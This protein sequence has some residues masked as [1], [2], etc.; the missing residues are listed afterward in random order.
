MTRLAPALSGRR[1]AAATGL[2]LIAGMAVQLAA[3]WPGIMVWDAIRQY[4]Q[5]LSSRYD[6]WHPPAMSWLWRQLMPLGAGPAP[7]LLLQL[8]LYWTGF[9]LLAAA[10]LRRGQPHTAL[11]T[12]LCAF[13]PIPFVLVGT[14]L[15]D[16]LMAGAL[17]CAAGLIGMRRQ[18]DRWLGC[19][20]AA[21]IM[22]AATLRFN[23]VAACLP[24][25]VATLPASWKNRPR[26]LA[27]SVAAC[28][29]LLALA[30]PAA[31][32]LLRA[33]PSGVQ[34]SLVIY[35]LGGIGRMS[36]ADAFPP[37]PLADPIAVNRG[38]YDPVSWDSYS[39]WVER[40]C[41]VGF[42]MLRS[43]FAAHGL[44]PYRWWLAQILA[45]PF[46]YVT[47]RL[48]H[49]DRNTHFLV[50]DDGAL[51][52]LSLR[53]DPNDWGFRLSPSRLRD[54]IGAI[55]AWSGHVPIGWPI[56]WIALGLG[57]LPLLRVLDREDPARPMMHSALLY[58]FSYLPLSVASEIRYH[59]WTMTG[60]AIA[61]A[62]VLCA[63][64]SGA[65]LSRRRLAA[66][67][68]SVTVVT[69]L[70]VGARLPS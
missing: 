4:G 12:G 52:G 29:A 42:A 18:D 53:S 65:P 10:A 33:E 63:L 40:P 54:T 69:L 22:A 15:K 3:F 59:L 48:A 6:D 11:A 44:S 13:L 24:L 17:L 38:C 28:F 58:A 47:H 16:S 32:R 2:L 68:L 46:A 50:D 62:S 56:W 20:A 7:M 41:P 9:A 36:D 60:T 51:P 26:R 64:A 39:W 14:V 30:M 45:H 23:A 49:F 66:A 70:C 8:L 67:F 61:V 37:L 57:C 27:A 34:L 35:D 19:A 21:L 5:A 25:L 31:N 1:T 43:A 55:A